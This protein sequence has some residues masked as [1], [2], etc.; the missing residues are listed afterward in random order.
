MVQDLAPRAKAGAVALVDDH[1][2]EEVSREARE[3]PAA[4]VVLA[5]QGLVDAEIEVA[6]E[7]RHSALEDG[8]GVAG[9]P[10]K[11]REA[12]VGLVAQHDAIGQEQDAAGVVRVQPVQPTGAGKLPGDLEGDEGLARAGCHGQQDA[13][14]VAHHALYHLGDGRLLEVEGVL[15]ALAPGAVRVEQRALEPAGGEGIPGIVDCLTPAPR[16]W[17]MQSCIALPAPP[18]VGRGREGIQIAALVH[19]K[20]VLDNAVPVGR[21]GKG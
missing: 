20:V 4:L 10:G 14:L 2:V 16:K 13:A 11:G 17:S 18:E 1:Q 6:V 21:V 19:K 7:A 12:V 8:P 15:A 3:E 5:P 9:A